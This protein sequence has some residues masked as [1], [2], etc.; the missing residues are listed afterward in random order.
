[1]KLCVCV[2]VFLHCDLVR[3]VGHGRMFKWIMPICVGLNG[4]C[5]HA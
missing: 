2:C 5:A 3:F 1:M 4:S